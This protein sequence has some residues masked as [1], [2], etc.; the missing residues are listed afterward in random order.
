MPAFR[1]STDQMSRT[2]SA[3]Q[4]YVRELEASASSLER[5]AGAASSTGD[6]AAAAAFTTM[7]FQW[8]EDIKGEGKAIGVLASNLF[9]A[10]QLYAAT[11]AAAVALDGIP[12][13]G[14]P[15]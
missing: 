15:S 10:A 14:G 4:P 3:L 1:V 8:S 6:G 2:A 13:I 7:C 5:V 11:E 9:F 12:L